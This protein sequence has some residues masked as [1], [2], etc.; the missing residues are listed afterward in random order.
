VDYHT[1]LTIISA[2]IWQQ[3]AFVPSLL[4]KLLS[5]MKVIVPIAVDT[6][7]Q[8]EQEMNGSYIGEEW[9][10]PKWAKVGMH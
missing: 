4:I 10:V 5:S 7:L 2:I 3:R 6:S 1:W 8:P 9:K